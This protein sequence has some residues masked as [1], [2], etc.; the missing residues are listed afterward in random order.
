MLRKPKFKHAETTTSLPLEGRD[1]HVYLY[2]AGSHV[3]EQEFS[4]TGREQFYI[5]KEVQPQSAEAQLKAVT[6]A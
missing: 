5:E 3:Q 1:I 2:E 6:K 4:T